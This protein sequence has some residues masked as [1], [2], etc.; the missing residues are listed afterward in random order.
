MTYYKNNGIKRQ[1][2]A[3]IGI[4][5]AK[6]SRHAREM[7]RRITGG[8]G[9]SKAARWFVSVNAD[10]PSLGMVAATIVFSEVLIPA[11]SVALIFRLL[12]VRCLWILLQTRY[13][14]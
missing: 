5:N 9:I 10:L 1:P 7:K 12:H 3:C 13:V 2:D 11:V 4:I 6:I 8:V 14:V